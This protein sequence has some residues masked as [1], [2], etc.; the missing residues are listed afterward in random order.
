MPH[1]IRLSIRYLAE[2]LL[3]GGS[4]DSRF[5]GLDR[6]VEGTRIHRRLQKQGGAGYT[7][8]VKLDAEIALEEF[9]YKLSGRADGVIVSDEGVAV[10]EIK[11]TARPLALVGEDDSP[12][13]WAQGCCYAHILCKRD[14]LAGCGVRLTYCNV[15]T[16][17]I[18]RFGRAYTAGELEDFVL[19]LLRAYQRWAR[20]EVEHKQERAKS[21]QKLRF[22]YG[23]YREGQRA[24]AVAAYQ[25]FRDGGRLFCCAPTGIGKTMSAL[26]PAMKAVGEGHGER[27]F[28]L[29]AKT[30]ARKAA[31]DALVR[32]RAAEPLAF[33]SVTMTAKDKICFLEERACLP[34]IC[35]YAKGYYERNM[36]VVYALAK[37]GGDFT[38]EAIETAAKEHSL[39]PYELSL[40][41]ALWCDCVICDYNYLFDPTVHLQRFFEAE[42]DYLFLVDEAHNLVERSRDMYSASLAKRSF[43]EFSKLVPKSHKRLRKAL[44]GLN[45]AFI[46]LRRRCEEE[47]ARVLKQDTPP[48]ELQK[49]L[50]QFVAAT[51]AFLEDHRGGDFENELLTLYFEALFYAE[52]AEGYGSHYTTL[53]Y[54][55]GGDIVVKL[56]C[57]DASNY[58]DESM[59]LGR[60][61]V[62]FS[63][64]LQP[65]GYYRQTLGGTREAKLLNLP[66]PFSREHL[67]LFIASGIS[68]KYVHR[69]ESLTEVA[70]MLGRLVA[71]KHG[72]YIAYFPSYSYMSQ[73]LAAFE[74]R[75]PGVEV[76]VQASGMEEAA[77]EAFLAAF[78]RDAETEEDKTMLGF[79]VMGGIFA[80]G[81][82]LPGDKLIGTAIVGVGLPQMGPVPDSIRE[83]YD[84][85]N[86]CGFE[87]AY[88]YPGMNKV[89]QAAGRVIR[90]ESDKGVVLLIDS[91]FAT[92]R[93]KEMF[94]QHW[95]SAEEVDPESLSRALKA[96]WAED[97]ASETNKNTR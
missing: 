49:P 16:G 14:G 29:T 35:P 13:H 92:A 60:A 83:Y 12:A 67:G 94:P 39:C 76:L 41:L 65:L 33:A 56:L 44:S 70:D 1:E 34:E 77:R 89:L 26:F 97:G 68:T 62:L 18:K 20:L 24:M 64:T 59:A 66:S 46:S 42:G 23:D 93:Y 4:I 54:K 7:P 75:W 63:A 5:S 69:E 17:E 3:R 53:I 78:E 22:P 55:Y 25:A 82:D 47:G 91:R 73:V 38:R 10:D 90:T 85:Q 74:S 8:E 79:C 15:D 11:T 71:A 36:D 58:L 31:Q 6:G 19:G 45:S 51:E 48:A 2:F 37:Q 86:G 87:Y 72:N 81:V 61:S 28:Y 43:F 40:D 95:H 80:E 27:I 52:V 50:A 84:E 32:L 30:V 9:V 88:Q 21:L 57:L 96:F